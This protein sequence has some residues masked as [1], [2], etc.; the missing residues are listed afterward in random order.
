MIFWQTSPSNHDHPKR[1]ANMYCAS[2]FTGTERGVDVLLNHFLGAV[3]GKATVEIDSLQSDKACTWVCID[4]WYP[5]KT[6][7]VAEH[8]TPKAI[9]VWTSV[10]PYYRQPKLNDVF[11]FSLS[12][13]DPEQCPF[14]SDDRAVYAARLLHTAH[15]AWVETWRLMDE[16]KGFPRRR[17]PVKYWIH[18]QP[19]VVWQIA[20]DW[21]LQLV[22]GH[23]PVDE[24]L[25]MAQPPTVI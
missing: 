17:W 4:W 24:N 13:A 20:D 8:L 5:G 12:I 16:V 10:Y 3:L 7:S 2:A 9:L 1:F 6:R 18:G 15:K 21:S 23:L 11:E 25:A 22:P 14:Y 19:E